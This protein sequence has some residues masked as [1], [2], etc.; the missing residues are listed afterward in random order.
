MEKVVNNTQ[1][2]AMS[3]EKLRQERAAAKR[4]HKEARQL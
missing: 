1:L 2:D 3:H 4:E